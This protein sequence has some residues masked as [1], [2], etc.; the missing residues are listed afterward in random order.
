ML[1]KSLHTVA[2]LGLLFKVKTGFDNDG[3]FFIFI[4]FIANE[5]DV[6][7]VT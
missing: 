7:L 3:R 2:M 4:Y 1:G 6:Y 5:V